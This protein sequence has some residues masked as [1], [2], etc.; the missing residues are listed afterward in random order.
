MLINK[1]KTLRVSQNKFERS[2]I[3]QQNGN[4]L[5]QQLQAHPEC[6]SLTGYL[7]P[8]LENWANVFQYNEKILHVNQDASGSGDILILTNFN[9][10]IDSTNTNAQFTYGSVQESMKSIP[11]REMEQLNDF[12]S[13]IHFLLYGQAQ[14]LRLAMA[15]TFGQT[16]QQAMTDLNNGNVNFGYVPH[17]FQVKQ[18]ELDMARN[19]YSD[20]S[21]DENVFEVEGNGFFSHK[22]EG[23]IVTILKGFIVIAAIVVVMSIV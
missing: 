9:V 15:N 22:M 16:L 8:R 23:V 3:M 1:R 12:G 18:Q 14:V 5:M 19:A 10:W 7:Y 20:D 2:Y 13:E 4:D 21:E 11:I 17:E 6:Y